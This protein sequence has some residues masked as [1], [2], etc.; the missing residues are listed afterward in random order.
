MLNSLKHKKPLL[1]TPRFTYSAIRS[2]SRWSDEMRLRSVLNS[3]VDYIYSSPS[4]LIDACPAFCRHL[5]RSRRYIRALVA[6]QR[7]VDSQKFSPLLVLKSKVA[8]PEKIRS[9]AKNGQIE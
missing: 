7:Y 3:E 8:L 9:R 4:P 2:I 5:H 6:D 1:I